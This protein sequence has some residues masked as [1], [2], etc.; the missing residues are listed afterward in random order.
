MGVIKLVLMFLGKKTKYK[1]HD[2]RYNIYRTLQYIVSVLFII[3]LYTVLVAAWHNANDL[4]DALN[5]LE[6]CKQNN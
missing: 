3:F 5:A 2:H 4:V 6:K 1:F